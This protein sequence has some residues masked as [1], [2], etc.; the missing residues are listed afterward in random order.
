MSLYEHLGISRGADQA[1]IKRAY[2]KMSLT[3]HPDKGGDADTFRK[4]Q[5]AYEV[6]SDE[7]RKSH[8]DMTGSDTE[9]QMPGGMPGGMPF[10]FDMHNLFGNMFGHGQGGPQ[11]RRKVQKGQP[12]VHDISLTLKDFYNGREI[13]L[14]FERQKFCAPCK[15]EGTDRYE[16]CGGCGGSG[17]KQT[18]VTMGPGMQAMMRGPCPEC[19]GQG[20]KPAGVCGE[21]KGLKFKAQERVLFAK[22]IPGMRPGEVLVFPGEC[23]DNHGHVEPG[24]VQIHLDD[25]DTDDNRFYR[26]DGDT[27]AIKV[28]L[29]LM[30]SLL[31]HVEK[32]TGHP[33]YP[34]IDLM[35][36]PGAQNGD[37]IIIEGKGMPIKN[38]GHAALHVL[39]SVTTSAA[40]RAI[41]LNN[42]DVITAWVHTSPDQSSTQD[43]SQ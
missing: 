17:A 41:L 24:D 30:Q 34:V 25:A 18:V 9:V 21:C 14:Q 2:R 33:G 37:V 8:Y 12:K 11:V 13:K 20:K 7:S 22:I 4:I 42:K 15:G 10:H 6:L 36:P 38:G 27:L 31:G 39:V 16:P 1:E 23:S 28:G 29:S 35:I 5:H 19:G 32:V 40:D 26:L 43:S 3:H